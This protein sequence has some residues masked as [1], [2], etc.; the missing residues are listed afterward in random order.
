MT[1]GLPK[2]CTINECGILNLDRLSG[3]GTHWTC[4]F[5]NGETKIYFDS[6]G[7]NVPHQLHKY[8]GKSVLHNDF[9]VQSF[10]TDIC[11]DM[12]VLVLFLLSHNEDFYDIVMKILPNCID[13]E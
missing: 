4:W 1:D 8:L 9:Q 10:G 5:V 13:E 12:C 6:Y 2:Q 11:G 3:P 7:A